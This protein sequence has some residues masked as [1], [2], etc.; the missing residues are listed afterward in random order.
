MPHYIRLIKKGVPHH[1]IPEHKEEME[2]LFSY[3]NQSGTGWWGV[4]EGV[5]SDSILSS[6]EKLSLN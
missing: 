1:I 6:R 5:Y 2:T 4:G 3:T